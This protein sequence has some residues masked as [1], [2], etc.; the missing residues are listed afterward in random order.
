[1]ECYE[2]IDL[3]G[4]ALEDRLAPDA[5]TGLQEHFDECPACCNY[6]NQL[7]VTR[8]ALKHLPAP[9]EH[10]RQRDELIARFVKEVR[11]G[12]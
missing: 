8:D 11:D 3:M 4:D 7:R 6:M 10:T 9:D 2:A 1:M 12:E 5:R